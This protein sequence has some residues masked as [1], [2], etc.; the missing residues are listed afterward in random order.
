[1]KVLKQDLINKANEIEVNLR[2]EGF[3]V[4]IS[5]NF[6]YGAYGFYFNFINYKGKKKQLYTGLASKKECFKNLEFLYYK[7]LANKDYYL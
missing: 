1:M 5:S 2:N 3:N 4:K 6:C 7:T